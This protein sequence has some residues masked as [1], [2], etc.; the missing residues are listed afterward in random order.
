[1]YLDVSQHTFFTQTTKDVSLSDMYPYLV[2]I[3]QISLMTGV[4]MVTHSIENLFE[5]I[6]SRVGELPLLVDADIYLPSPP[7]Y[8]PQNNLNV[9][10]KGNIIFISLFYAKSV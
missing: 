10:S 4:D 5:Q 8:L 6:K 3:F 1:M 7:S 2:D 9:N